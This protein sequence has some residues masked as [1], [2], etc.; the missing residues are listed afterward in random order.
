MATRDKTPKC[1][2]AI[3]GGSGLYA[4]KGLREV[5]EVRV[6]TPF[7]EP[8]DA[9]MTGEIDGVRCAFLP[10]HGRGHRLLPSEVNS[11][12]NIWALKSLGVERILSLSAVGSLREDFAPE[13]FVFPDQLVDETKRRDSTFFGEGVVAHVAFADPFC[14][15]MSDLLYRTA[16]ELGLKAHRGGTYICM[17]GPAF[18]TKAES[19]MHRKL[20]YSIIGMTAIGEAKLAREAEICYSP[21]AMVTDYDCWKVGEEVSSPK[22]IEHLMANVSNAQRL[23]AAV[24]GRL[25]KMRRDCPCENAL[26][27]AVFTRPD[28]MDR[29]TLRRLGPIVERYHQVPS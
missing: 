27:D 8:S 6:K 13:H 9:I 17:E 5:R 24:V 20:G 14:D 11:R 2:S 21:V 22:V 19:E 28:A 15:A 3:I 10:R 7:G 18:S 26:K 16:R 1:R 25:E 12:A 29:G 4:M 23:V